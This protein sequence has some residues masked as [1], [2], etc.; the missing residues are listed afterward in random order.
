MHIMKTVD[1][2]EYLRM[3]NDRGGAVT[4]RQ[5]G[6]R[7]SLLSLSIPLGERG[8]EEE[9]QLLAVMEQEAYERGVRRMEA[10]FPETLED[11][12]SVLESSGYAITGCARILSLDTK[13]ILASPDI[14]KLT[15]S[16]SES[17]SCKHLSE[18]SISQFE[19]VY[20]LL[21]K[22]G[23]RITTQDM[24]RFS[25]RFSGVVFDQSTHPRAIILCTEERDSLHVELLAGASKTSTPYIVR[26]LKELI[27]DLAKFGAAERYERI[28]MIAANGSINAILNKMVSEASGMKD[29]V[30]VMSAD[31]H[32]TEKTNMEYAVDISE[33]SDMAGE[34]R[35]EIRHI[36]YQ[37]N[38]C[39]KLSW[40][41]NM[42]T[43]DEGMGE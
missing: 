19:D 13:M 41:K 33:D 42:N 5:Q 16:R 40:H 27:H 18:L 2:D 31:K 11:Y 22:L 32:L 25:S 29:I 23:I 39:W 12:A 43:D 37:Y 17:G 20:A 36:P 1:N 21:N 9:V 4:M 10:F 38:I 3:E 14:K 24:A 35:R 26:A 6:D 30:T 7:G 34:W 28:T 15:D 8:G